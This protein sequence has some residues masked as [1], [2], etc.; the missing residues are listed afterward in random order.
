LR[1][2]LTAF[3]QH[4]ADDA[5]ECSQKREVLA[6]SSPPHSRI[7]ASATGKPFQHV[8]NDDGLSAGCVGDLNAPVQVIGAAD[9]DHAV[10]EEHPEAIG[11]RSP[12]STRFAHRRSD[13]SSSRRLASAFLSVRQHPDN[14]LV[15]VLELGDGTVLEL[16]KQPAEVT[17]RPPSRREA[18]TSHPAD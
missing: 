10:L 3:G 17:Q 4:E 8:L 15:V 13:L 18:P 14:P 12:A 7:P 1:R 5:A 11:A 9:Q 6:P 16:V 2:A